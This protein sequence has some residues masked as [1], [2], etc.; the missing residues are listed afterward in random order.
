MEAA[1]GQEV[2]EPPPL[3]VALIPQE[4]PTGNNWK[5]SP[6]HPNPPVL[7]GPYRGTFKQESCWPA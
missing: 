7:E 6:I 4:L 3:L 1:A 5:V 2:G